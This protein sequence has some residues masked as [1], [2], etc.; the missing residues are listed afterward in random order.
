MAS[1]SHRNSVGGV[2]RKGIRQLPYVVVRDCK[3]NEIYQYSTLE[4]RFVSDISS[5]ASSTVAPVREHGRM[6][7]PRPYISFWN[8]ELNNGQMSLSI[9][10]RR[11][12]S[13]MPCLL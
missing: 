5:S 1:L 11:G 6:E 3:W 7:T 9:L 8:P 12:E 2:E 10:S 13:R 4:S